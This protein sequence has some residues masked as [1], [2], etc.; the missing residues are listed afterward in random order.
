MKTY[1]EIGNLYGHA[2]VDIIKM[3]GKYYCLSE[4]D[5]E[6]YITCWEVEEPIYNGYGYNATA[7]DGKEYRFVPVY[8]WQ[9]ENIDL[10]ELEENGEEWQKATEI[11]NF[12]IYDY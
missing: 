11:V 9:E 2:S 8:R 5:G 6:Q 10:D 4:W 3:N 7:I 12:N 1:E